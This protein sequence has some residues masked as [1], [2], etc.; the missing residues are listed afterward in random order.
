MH[1]AILHHF[2][3]CSFVYWHAMSAKFLLSLCRLFNSSVQCSV[4]ISIVLQLHSNVSYFDI[5]FIECWDLSKNWLVF[6]KYLRFD[7]FEQ[8]WTKF[9][10]SLNRRVCSIGIRSIYNVKRKRVFFCVVP[11]IRRQWRHVPRLLGKKCWMS[12][13]GRI[14]AHLS[15]RNH[16]NTKGLA[17]FFFT[18]LPSKRKKRRTSS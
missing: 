9:A 17:R 6:K 18:I 1:L 13:K 16:L 2:F 3:F 4:F 7:L 12:R 10:W 5:R 15:G 11:D 14:F 8:F